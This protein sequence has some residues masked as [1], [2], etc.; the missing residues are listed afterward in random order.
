[1][2][3]RNDAKSDEAPADLLEIWKRLKAEHDAAAADA[4]ASLAAETEARLRMATLEAPMMALAR[5]MAE[6]PARSDADLGA[7]LEVWRMLTE[8]DDAAARSS[9]DDLTDRLVRSVAEALASR[10]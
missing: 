1:M 6:S 2:Y 8:F 4:A 9:L 10:R 3:D 5:R 7:K